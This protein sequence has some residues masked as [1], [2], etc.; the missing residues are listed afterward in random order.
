MAV[1]RPESWLDTLSLELASDTLNMWGTFALGFGNFFF[2]F[3]V[4]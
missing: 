1:P 2:F 3:L 4:P